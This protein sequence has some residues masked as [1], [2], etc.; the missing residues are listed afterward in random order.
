MTGKPNELRRCDARGKPIHAAD[1][2]GGC[3]LCVIDA[4]EGNGAD[5]ATLAGN[6]VLRSSTVAIQIV[7]NG[8]NTDPEV[9][10][11]TPHRPAALVSESPDAAF[12]VKGNDVQNVVPHYIGPIF[13]RFF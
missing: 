8:S 9:F 3:Y 6:F 10:G 12:K 13:R 1:N 2:R 11:D 4:G 5:L 7:V